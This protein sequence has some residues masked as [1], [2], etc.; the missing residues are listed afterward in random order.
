MTG[1]RQRRVGHE[2]EAV[3]HAPFDGP[4][5]AGGEKAL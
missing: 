4:S 1:L 5:Y 2:V 3:G